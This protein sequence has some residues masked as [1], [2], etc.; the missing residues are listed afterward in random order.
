MTRL[1]FKGE[2]LWHYNSDLSGSVSISFGPRESCEFPGK[3][4]LEFMGHWNEQ[5]GE[6][7]AEINANLLAAAKRAEQYIHCA[8]LECRNDEKGNAKLSRHA[9]RDLEMLQRAIREASE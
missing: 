5:Q 9:E 6:T 1:A 8:I 7:V 3:D 2:T 4:L